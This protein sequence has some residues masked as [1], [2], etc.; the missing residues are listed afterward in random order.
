M[1][2]AIL[3]SDASAKELMALGMSA[4]REGVETEEQFEILLEDGCDEIQGFLL[5]SPMAPADVAEKLAA[6]GES[7]VEPEVEPDEETAAA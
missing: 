1:D 4:V 2:S 6:E 5:G 7:V 3:S